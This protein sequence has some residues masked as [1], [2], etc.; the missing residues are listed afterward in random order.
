MEFDS[1]SGF[2]GDVGCGDGFFADE[3]AE[4]F[5]DVLLGSDVTHEYSLDPSSQGQQGDDRGGYEDEQL[6]GQ[7]DIGEEADK[8]DDKSPEGEEEYDQA[9]HGEFQQQ[10]D[11]CQEAP[12]YFGLEKVLQG[13]EQLIHLEVPQ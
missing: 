5:G 8:G 10:Q 9:W 4:I 6:D 7:G 3:L 2:G 13:G 12:Y 1:A 11:D